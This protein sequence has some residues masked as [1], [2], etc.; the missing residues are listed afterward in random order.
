MTL[1]ETIREVQAKL[2]VEQDGKAGPQTWAAIHA[3]IVGKKPLA[4]IRK[5]ADELSVDGGMVDTR[6]EKTIATLHPKV[7]PYA[8]ALVNAAAAQGIVIKLVSGTRS[9]EEQ[10]ELYARYKAGGPL[11]APPGRS[12]HNF[13]IA[14]DI[15]VFT[16]S[17]DPEKART[18]QPESPAYAAVGALAGS[19]GLDWGGNWKT[20]K[21]KPHYQLRPAWAAELSESSMV[22][23]LA[24]RKAAGIDP[25]S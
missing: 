16:G 23:E 8:R 13:G 10:A 22:S 14:F 20:S 6:S 11:A 3:S 12:N 1:D 5:A 15:G 18:Y 17:S 19:I 9:Y 4:D 2:G 21:D 25:F 24:R 7:P